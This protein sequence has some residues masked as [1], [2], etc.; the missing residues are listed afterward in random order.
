[1]V[2]S[3]NTGRMR[4]EGSRKGDKKAPAQNAGA[5]DGFA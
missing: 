4:S 3:P 5:G 2:L 1:M